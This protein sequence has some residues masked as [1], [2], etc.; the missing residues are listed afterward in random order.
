MRLKLKGKIQLIT[1]SLLILLSTSIL[2]IVY[3]QVHGVIIKN[4]NTSLD[5]YIKL[6]SDLLEQK[7]PGDWRVEGDKLYKGDKLINSDTE[8]VDAVKSATDS[9][10]TIF[11]N[12]TRVSTNVFNNG[13]R[14]LGT[15]VSQSV[16][17]IVLKQGREYSGEANV[18]GI[19]HQAKYIPLK[20]STGKAIGILFIGIEKGKITAQINALMI[21]MGIITLI[22]LA[23]AIF[24]SAMFTNPIIRNIKKIL[25]ALKN[26]SQGDLT[27]SCNVVSSDETKDISEE[28]N[29]MQNNVSELVAQIKDSSSTLKKNSDALTSI[30]HEMSTASE[31]VANAI[32][33]VASGAGSQSN[34]LIEISGIINNFGNELEAIVD[35]IKTIDNS[36]REITVL[37]DGSNSDMKY[38]VESIENINSTFNSFMEKLLKLGKN[39]GKINDITSLINSVAEQ[40]NLLAL[41]AAIEAARAGEAGKGFSVVAEEIRKL[42]EQSK[43]S[44]QDINNL[45]AEISRDN[46]VI[47]QSSEGMSSEI[48]NQINV[49][50]AAIASFKKIILSLNE[51]TPLIA[52][53]NSNAGNISK[54]KEGI[55]DKIEALSSVS[56]EVSASSEEISASSEQMSAS[57]QEVTATA[58]TLNSMT[59]AMMAQVNRFKLA[60]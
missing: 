53:V 18:V 19:V 1:I 6:S 8:F 33:E 20:D 32:Q 9:P 12:D 35:S 50:N 2:G 28:L 52:S 27:S 41:N 39:I 47:V 14:A 42:A 26:I 10:A 13:E 60:H 22:V 24:A 3:F 59:D 34:D 7:Y 4:L 11:L 37:A 57:A 31:E 58:Q 23:L 21:T 38:L 45:I 30:S 54:E 29:N 51:V 15:K 5:A 17:D 43:N 48:R 36:S 46:T 56:Q 40:T 49:I 55:I 25:G 16:T 44:S